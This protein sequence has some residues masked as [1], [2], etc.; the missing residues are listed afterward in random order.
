MPVRLRCST[1]AARG[2]TRSPDV[3]WTLLQA[4][5]CLTGIAGKQRGRTQ[6]HR[7][8]SDPMRSLAISCVTRTCI[9]ASTTS[10][11]EH[12]HQ[13]CF[14][15]LMRLAHAPVT[16]KVRLRF[17]L[18]QSSTVSRA[19]SDTNIGST[20]SSDTHCD[21]VGQEASMRVHAV[22]DL[23]ADYA[24]NLQWW[25]AC[26]APAPTRQFAASRLMHCAAHVDQQLWLAGARVC[27][28][29]HTRATQW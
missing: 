16:A 1:E 17:A 9:K 7:I 20:A 5:S 8:T 10:S 2:A 3:W 18:A 19:R 27:Q 24:Q 23:H 29:P 25:V 4:M 6:R 11:D 13:A 12:R 14:A 22:S 28:T 15:R 21:G 26:P